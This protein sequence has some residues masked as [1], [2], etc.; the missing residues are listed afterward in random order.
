MSHHPPIFSHEV[1]P[2]DADDWLKIIGKKLDITQCNDW[3]KVLYASGRFKGAA[4]DWWDAV[5]AAHANADALTWQE[6]QVN[7]RAH[8]IPLRIMKLKKKEFLSLTQGNMTISEHRDRFTQLSHYTPEEVDS[9]EK[10]QER[11]LEGLIGPFHTSYRATVSPTFRLCWTKQFALKAKGKSCQVIRG[12]TKGRPTEIPIRTTPKVLSSAPKIRVE[13]ITIKHNAL[14][15]KVR[16][17][18][19]TKTSREVALRPV[20]GLVGN[21]R[22]V[23]EAPWTHRPRRTIQLP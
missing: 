1:D 18:I 6:F 10:H 7:F 11:F 2:L 21:N 17:A 4:S 14:D 16:G 22:I 8:H 12:S 3:E 20:K 23:K 5:T 13:T 15:N 19:N 9:D